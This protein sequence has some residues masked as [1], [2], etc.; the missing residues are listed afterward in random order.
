[1]PHLT[2]LDDTEL[3]RE[4]GE[5]KTLIERR[6]GA[7]ATIAYPFG[8]W[9]ARVATAARDAGY[10]FAF[11]LPQGPQSVYGPHCIPRVNVDRRDDGIRFAFKTSSPGRRFLLSGAAERVRAL[12]DAVR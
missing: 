2:T 3:A 8:E 1:H 12:R 6:L 7:C 9:D 11:S 5:S 10:E 4:L